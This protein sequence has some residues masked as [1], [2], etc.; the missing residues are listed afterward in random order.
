MFQESFF[1]NKIISQKTKSPSGKGQRAY[2][3]LAPPT[4]RFSNFLH[5]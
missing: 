2:Y 4:E 1:F 3:C 5:E